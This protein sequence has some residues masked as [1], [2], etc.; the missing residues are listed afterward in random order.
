[1]GNALYVCMCTYN[2]VLIQIG[3]PSTHVVL[4]WA[5]HV[6]P[7]S[8]FSIQGYAWGGRREEAEF[9]SCDIR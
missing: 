4:D 9:A 5:L 1:M 8:I 7:V 2:D 3:Q 6:L